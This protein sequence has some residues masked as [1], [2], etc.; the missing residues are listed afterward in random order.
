MLFTTPT[1]FAV[2]GL[3]LVAGWLLGLASHSG[4][5]KW[6]ERYAAEREAHAAARRDADARVAE[7]ERR[8]A[9]LER[10]RV[11]PAPAT[12]TAAPARTRPLAAARPAY[13]AGERRGW[14]DWNGTRTVR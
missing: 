3:V 2:L 14:F 10:E 12:P 4:G 6:K 13:P 7:V 11:V 9:E 8:H 5:R 1:Q